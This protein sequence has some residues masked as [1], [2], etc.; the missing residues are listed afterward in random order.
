MRL[1]LVALAAT[2]AVAGG[3]AAVPAAPAAAASAPCLPEA[4]SPVCRS[5]TGRV[6]AVNDGDTLSVDITGDGTSTPRSIRLINVQ[7]MEQTVYSPIAS[8][9][10]GECH[11]LVATARVEQLV[12]AGGGV[13]R[14][15]AQHASSSSRSRPLRS[16]SVKINGVWRDIG[17]DL[18][19]RGLALWQPFGTE[20]A[21]NAHYRLAEAR[22]ARDRQGLFD[23]DFCGAGPAQSGPIGVVVNY[24]A[25][26][27]DDENLNGEWVRV[28]NGRDTP[29]AVGNWWIRDSGLRRYTFPAGT[30]VPAHG[31][32]QVHVGRGKATATQK[33]WGLTAPIFDNPTFDKQAHGDGAYLFDPQ[34]DLRAWMLYPCVLNCGDP[35]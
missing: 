18:L 3:L 23:T 4:G 1:R 7:A 27:R 19:G 6:T 21:W 24:D 10:R 12:R 17:L 2:M 33:Y 25:P 14:L 26:G 30:E 32:V 9:R 20:W 28:D 15:T 8:R 22:A 35:A 34:G 5:W 13:V 29:L 11:S 16:V 31:S